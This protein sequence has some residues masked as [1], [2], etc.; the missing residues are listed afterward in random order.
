MKQN[1]SKT[2]MP[3]ILTFRGGSGGGG[4]I[5]GSISA[6]EVAFGTA[7][8]TIG[9][10]SDFTYDST[11]NL[12]TTEKIRTQVVVDVRNE[13]GSAIGAGSVVYV[14]GD[15]TLIDLAD[16]SD[17]AK[18]PSIGI[19]TNNLGDNQNGYAAISGQVNGLDGSAG[20]T[21]FDSTIVAA[22][23]GK[24]VYVSPI[25]PGRLTITK[26]TSSTHLIQNVGRILD[27]T[28]PN[29]KIVVNN[30]GR[31]ND[32]PNYSFVTTTDTTTD[33][34]NSRYLAAGSGISITDNG[35]GSTVA[36]AS[37]TTLQNAYDNGATIT[38]SGSTDI[39]YTLTSGGFSIN[40]AQPVAFGSSN[41]LSSF[42][43]F[44]NAGMTLQARENSSLL[45]TANEATAQTLNISV[46]NSGAGDAF[47]S[48][49]A[50]QTTFTG[51]QNIVAR[52]D[53][54][55]AFS[56]ATA[57]SIVAGVTTGHLVY[58]SSSGYAKADATSSSTAFAIAIAVEN[59]AVANGKVVLSGNAFVVIMGTAP[60]AV[61]VRLYL[62]TTAGQATETAPSGSGNVVYEI[63]FALS[64]S[65]AFGSAYP[66]LFQPQFIEVIP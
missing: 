45:L 65:P 51:S 66:V 34:P 52:G 28:G 14:N 2:V 30:I 1:D 4:G 12:L 59:G 9:G 17:S 31:T 47:I 25:N 35:G 43:V 56:Y 40:G 54:G 27:L 41:E 3:S 13:T 48:V 11:I 15:N 49:A 42:S 5:G 55:A 6:T 10:E 61:G 50:D 7:A 18:M 19:V 64:T 58:V 8:N 32:V 57:L 36:I 16:A 20:N 33:M 53:T 26:P 62:D 29:V 63:G 22:D 46:T 24:I 23:V 60:T 39:A 38:T 37:S 21:V 44:S